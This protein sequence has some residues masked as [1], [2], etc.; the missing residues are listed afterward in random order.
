MFDGKE[1]PIF[2]SPPGLTRGSMYCRVKPGNDDQGAIV[3][4]RIPL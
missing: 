1:S 4:E 3:T 2:A